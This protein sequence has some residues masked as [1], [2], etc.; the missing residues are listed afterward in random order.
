MKQ[1]LTYLLV[2]KKN[3][4]VILAGYIKEHVV[5][6]KRQGHY[7]TWAKKTLKYHTKT[8]RRLHRLFD[9]DL[10][11]TKKKQLKIRKI[12][13]NKS[14]KKKFGIKI[15]GNVR[16]ALLFDKEKPFVEKYKL[17]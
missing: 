8:I 7:N 6:D 1:L 5:E 16:E 14:E 11:L 17:Y 15:P 10:E 9:M 2:L 12:C 4:P 3:E 13:K